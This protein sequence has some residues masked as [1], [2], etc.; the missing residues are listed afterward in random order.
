MYVSRESQRVVEPRRAVAQARLLL[1]NRRRR[2]NRGLLLVLVPEV[3]RVRSAERRHE[4]GEGEQ[5]ARREDVSRRRGERA[6]QPC[7]EDAARVGHDEPDGDGRCAA[8]VRRR[9]VGAPCG[10][11]RGGEVGAG[12]GEEE[13]GVLDVVLGRAWKIFSHEI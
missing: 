10:E 1:V 11:R 3:P 5:D 4:D 7:R 2:P 13:G 9:V 8:D 6:Q 12:D